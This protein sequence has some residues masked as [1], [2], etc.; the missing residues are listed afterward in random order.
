MIPLCLMWCKIL[1]SIVSN[2]DA[3]VADN[4]VVHN[5][6][7]QWNVL[8]TRQIQDWEMDM[9]LSF[10]DRLYSISARPGEGDKLVWNP[11]KKGLFEVRSF[12]EELIR[13]DGP[14]F[15]YFPYFPWKNIWRVKAPTMVVFFVWLAAL[16]KIL[17]HDNLR[18]RNVIVIEWC[19]LCK[20][21]GESIDHLLLHCEVARDLWNYILILSGVEWVMPLTVLELLKSWGAAI[22]CGH[23]KEAWRLAPL[24]LLWCIWRERNAWLFE[25]VETSI[26]ELR[27]RLLNTLYIWI[28]PHHSLSVFLLM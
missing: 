21:S 10:F 25:D 13:K 24:C 15:P 17:T 9:V 8:F 6:V 7:I 22:G 19:C 20:K 11:S 26:V 12:Y 1:F 3:M 4:L 18:K 23:A 14:S 27:K 2:K 16:G 5:G 28:A